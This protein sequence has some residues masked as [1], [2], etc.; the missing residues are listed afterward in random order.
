MATGDQQDFISRIKSTLPPWFGS[1]STP[2]LDALLSGPARALSF[3]YSLIQYSKLQMRIKTATDGWLDLMSA[4]YFGSMLPRFTA[5]S[6]DSFRARIL[7]NLLRERVT[8]RSLIKVLTQLTGRAPLVFEPMRPLDT[9]AYGASPPTMGYGLAGAYGSMLMGGQALVIA[10]RPATS[11]IPYVAG[12]GLA[13]YGG[14]NLGGPGGYGSGQI[15]YAS[16]SMIK[17]AVND[18]NIYAAVDSVKPVATVIWT[19]IQN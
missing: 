9:G 11:G 2:V 10:Y 12:Y 17:G 7:F 6:D 1:G 5:E 16:M 4:D 14:G 15:E 18:A 3:A 19:K 8:R 13:D